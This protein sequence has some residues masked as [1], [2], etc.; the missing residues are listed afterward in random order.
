MHRCSNVALLSPCARVEDES[1]KQSQTLERKTQHIITTTEQWDVQTRLDMM[2]G[3]ASAWREAQFNT[4]L[5][6]KLEAE[7]TAMVSRLEDK[8]KQHLTDHHKLLY[9]EMSS[10]LGAAVGSTTFWPAASHGL[11]SWQMGMVG[12]RG[13]ET[14]SVPPLVKPVAESEECGEA[15]TPQRTSTKEK[16]KSKRFEGLKFG[17]S[18][19]MSQKPFF[20]RVVGSTVFEVSCSAL[21]LL[22][23]IS[24]ALEVQYMGFD[25]GFNIEHPDAPESAE[26]MWPGA[27]SAFRLLPLV[28]T[29]L[30]LIEF[31]LRLGAMKTKAFVSGWMWFDL[32]LLILGIVDIV[33]RLS[34]SAFLDF[35]PA[36]MRTAR[37]ARMLRMMK[38]LKS[39]EGFSSMFLL[40][41]SIQASTQA[42]IWSILLLLFTMTC[43]GLLMNQLIYGYL[44]DPAVDPEDQRAVFAYF[45]T[46]TKMLITMFELTLGNWAPPSRLLMSHI[47]EWWGLFIVFYRCILCFALVNVTAAVFITETNRVAAGDDEVMI[48]R[49]E[50]TQR[51]NS[52]KLQEIFE[53]LDET[54]DGYVT[55][56]EF[57]LLLVDDVM[58]KFL[59][60]MDLDVGDLEDLFK[61]LD[62]GDGQVQSHEFINGINTLRGQAKN[63]DLLSLLKISRRMS[64]TLERLDR[65]LLPRKAKKQA[66]KQISQ[67]LA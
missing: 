17:S 12:Q 22:N 54:G 1:G 36:M 14:G 50:R 37:I 38:V 23:T 5:E 56:D 64:A 42:L 35:N 59:S 15:E 3:T 24:M 57:Q 52:Q 39:R 10:R 63:I 41:K 43:V 11:E 44:T 40:M 28:F 66:T 18:T 34:T 47:S 49:K 21:I 48:M 53:E 19:A 29:S 51:A 65:G 8:L 46:Y 31:I 27:A 6:E 4:W 16:Y 58:R 9:D 45:G 2:Q 30:F 33:G 62:D 25:V 13:S 20:D 7:R 32:L 61:L 26:E 60:T 55:W 67:I